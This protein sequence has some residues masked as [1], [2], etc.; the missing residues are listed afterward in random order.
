[1]GGSTAGDG[2]MLRVLVVDDEELPRRRVKE[3]TEAHPQLELIGE[4][5]DGAEALDRIVAL[6][7]DLVFLDIRMPALDGFQVVASLDDDA[8]P[9]IVFVTAYDVH[10]IRAFEVGAFDY[11]L[12]PI[13]QARFDAAVQRVIDRTAAASVRELREFAAR[14][15]RTRGYVIRLV[16]RRGG[17]HY[18][19]QV[20]DIDWLESEGNYVRLHCG[21]DE[22]LV[23]NTMREI[24]EKLDPARFVRI[25]RSCMVAMDRVRTI[26]ARKHGEYTLHLRDGTRLDSSR[27]YSPRIRAIVRTAD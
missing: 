7:P 5:V 19:V 21:T 9:A 25:H 12:K 26:E 1:M 20:R 4:A 24:E 17:R 15:E 6:H 10:A 8:M 27:T 22:H 18:I 23:R 16:A 2:M 13:T 11:L 14:M 3:L